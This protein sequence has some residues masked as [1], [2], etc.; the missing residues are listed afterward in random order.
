VTDRAGHSVGP[1]VSR[2]EE[3][4]ARLRSE[5][6]TDG[7]AVVRACS[8]NLVVACADDPAD[9]EEAGALVAEVSRTAP[10]RALVIAPTAWPGAPPLEVFVSAHCHRAAGGSVV[11]SEQVTLRP[12]EKG[13]ELVPGT[14]LQLLVEEMPVFTWWRRPSLGADPLF[15]PLS[16]MSD[17]LIVNGAGFADPAARLRELYTA[18]RRVTFKGHA[19]DVTWSRLDP[20]REAVASFFDAGELRAVL[21]GITAVTIRAG[22]PVSGEG[23][24]VAGAYVAGWLSSRLGLRS[25]RGAWRRADGLPVRLHLQRDP[26]LCAGDVALTRIEAGHLA[27]TVERTAAQ[28]DIVRLS[29]EGSPGPARPRTIKLPLR[30]DCALLCGTLQ[31]PDRDPVFEAALADATR[32]AAS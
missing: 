16:E 22:G 4:F 6:P 8:H 19:A 26:D 3:E 13:I 12:A 31:R 10:G 25:S 21:D 1:D 32:M 29:V 24:T 15:R 17:R 20:W 11:C 7:A 5:A 28:S 9:V 27:C 14:L 30:D 2:V 23:L 18:A